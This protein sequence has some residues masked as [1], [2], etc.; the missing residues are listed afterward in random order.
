MAKSKRS[1]R[2]APLQFIACEFGAGHVYLTTEGGT[3]WNALRIQADALLKRKDLLARMS[4]AETEKVRAF[5][6]RRQE[7]ALQ[8]AS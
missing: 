6:K 7:L 4:A 1:T 2:P 8:G 5:A 3:I